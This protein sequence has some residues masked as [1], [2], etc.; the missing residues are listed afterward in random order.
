[1]RRHLVSTS[2][3]TCDGCG[4]KVVVDEVLPLED[5]PDLRW[6]YLTITHQG[7]AQA[8]SWDLCP[9]CSSRSLKDLEGK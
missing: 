7:L 4:L 1:M 8:R 2:E 6:G 9:S 3:R 5:R